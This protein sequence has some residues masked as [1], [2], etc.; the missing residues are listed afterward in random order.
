MS[1]RLLA[2]SVVFFFLEFIVQAAVER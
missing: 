1:E 2:C